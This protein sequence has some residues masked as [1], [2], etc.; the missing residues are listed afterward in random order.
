MQLPVQ[1]AQ[2]VFSDVR[3]PVQQIQDKVGP[4]LGNV[5]AGLNSAAQ[6]MQQMQQLQNETD[7]G[8]AYAN[9]FSPKVR[10]L[11]Q[12]YRTL[13][14]KDAV[15]QLPAF[16]DQI[17]KIR[18]DTSSGLSNKLTQLNFD[19]ISRQRTERE[20]GG[21]NDYASGQQKVYQAQTSD[22]MMND[23][24][25]DGA[26]NYQDPKR[27]SS[28]LASIVTEA[29]QFGQQAGQNP[30]VIEQ[31][32]QQTFDK[33]FATSVQSAISQ[34]DIQ[35]A[36]ALLD[37]ASTSGIPVPGGGT[38]KITPDVAFK[39]RDT[40]KP[41]VVAQTANAIADNAIQ[42]PG[43]TA[44]PSPTLITAITNQESN[45]QDFEKDGTP[46]T[47]SAGAK[48]S[49]QVTDATAKNPGFGI[50]PVSSDVLASGDPKAIASEYNRVGQ[51]YIS[52][53]LKKYDGNATLALAAY[54]AG[55]GQVDKW[56]QTI[57]DPRTSAISA[58]DFA[59]QI[60]FQ[61]TRNYVHSIL[62]KSP[63][64]QAVT[65][66]VA[67]PDQIK[68]NMPNMLA[69]VQ[70]QANIQFPGDPNAQKLAVETFQQKTGSILKADEDQLSAQH[71]T[72]MSAI[73]G[74][75]TQKAPATM[76]ELLQDPNASLAYANLVKRGAVLP[77]TVNAM[78][79]KNA[80]GT[81]DP[82]PSLQNQT[83]F[84]TALGEAKTNPAQFSQE[85]LSGLYG[86]IPF[87]QW[88]KLKELQAEPQAAQ[89]RKGPD[90]VGALNVLKGT[91]V[92]PHDFANKGKDTDTLNEFS[93]R[94][95]D[96]L[97][98]FQAQNNRPANTE[99][100]RKIGSDLTA[101][102]S[103]PGR[104]W[105]TSNYAA[106]QIGGK[107]LPVPASMIPEITDSLK[108]RGIQPTD[109]AISDTYTRFLMQ[110]S[111]KAKQA[112]TGVNLE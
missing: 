74:A 107:E 16:Q 35:G 31:R 20:L 84:Y 86:Q 61:E 99:D 89:Q 82:D 104:W 83:T 48:Y 23:F 92:I 21:M 68:S 27:L 54:N 67:T 102:V 18:Q 15:D 32:T 26:T 63:Q 3:M 109:A 80:T 47:S 2:T 100:I 11:V 40:L 60:P 96:R 81:N 10:A 73:A 87:S 19:Q 29:Q 43:A 85:D 69:Q 41:H 9:D 8:N 6:S 105:G 112:N 56:T 66:V 52:A 79:Q 103:V 49:M 14:G 22:A 17:A 78:L 30:A 37:Q 91:G 1:E 13:Q 64:E 45:G 94:L 34:G 5:G 42:S 108:R 90:I 95:A 76:Q 36:K 53:L 62:K 38:A 24:A 59:Q 101:Q 88:Q 58:Q 7:A 4:A 46:V 50:K 28:N 72:L 111:N 71:S 70:E 25:Q 33:L 98:Q 12:Q 55:P 106:Y 93:G 65:S 75:N 110:N 77:S 44:T 57:G 97:D 39:L 51:E